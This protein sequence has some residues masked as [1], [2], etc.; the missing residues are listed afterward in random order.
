M[1]EKTIESGMLHNK[2]TETP[3]DGWRVQGLPVYTVL[4]GQ[5]IMAD[6]EIV[7]PPAGRFIKPNQRIE[8]VE[9]D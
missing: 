1:A 8:E 6:G 7:G 4:R 5:V 2:N 9:D 3:F